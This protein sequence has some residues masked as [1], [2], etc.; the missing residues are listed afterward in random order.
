MIKIIKQSEEVLDYCSRFIC[1]L[2]FT[3]P[4][5]ASEKEFKESLDK[6][7][8]NPHKYRNIGVIENDELIGCFSFLVI[9]EE[10]YLEML[11]SV[12]DNQEAVHQ[13]RDYLFQ[14]FH[15][16]ECFFVY[17]PRNVHI[18]AMLQNQGA[19]FDTEQLKM[20]L[21]QEIEFVPSN[22]IVAY[23]DNYEKGYKAIHQD[24]EHYWTAE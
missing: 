8:A 20:D 3:D 2:H 19:T 18:Q 4:N 13:M 15:G 17:N 12:T 10:K 24:D 1:D 16:Y 7:T 6:Y 5:H 9:P 14:E 21:K 11:I 23:T 22:Q